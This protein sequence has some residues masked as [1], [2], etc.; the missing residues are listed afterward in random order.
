M[1]TEL[2]ESSCAPKRKRKLTAA[3]A[4][5]LSVA[6]PGARNATVRLRTPEAAV[7]TGSVLADLFRLI[8]H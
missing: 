5:R 4:V 6:H 8:V 1:V 7:R 3:L 2:V